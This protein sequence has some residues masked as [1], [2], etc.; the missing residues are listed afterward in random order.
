MGDTESVPQP[1]DD[2]SVKYDV[3]KQVFTRACKSCQA[4]QLGRWCVDRV[5]LQVSCVCLVR[6]FGLV[7]A[8]LPVCAGTMPQ[9][10][11]TG[12]GSVS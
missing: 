7:R 1:Y 6:V 5:P 9:W 2:G 10:H 11:N 8:G 3:R 4:L 12:Y